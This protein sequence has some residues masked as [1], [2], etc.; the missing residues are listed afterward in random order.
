MMILPVSGYQIRTSPT[1]RKLK[2]QGTVAPS[3]V[4]RNKS[5]A[6]AQ[7]RYIRGQ[8]IVGKGKAG[9]VFYIDGIFQP[10]KISSRC[11]AIASATSSRHGRA[12]TWT[13]IGSPSGEV[14]TRTVALGQPVRLCIC[15]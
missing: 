3:L 12:A 11:R 9:T 4:V 7:L 15:M 8:A 10:P 5:H 2:R 13:L 6:A 14:P 1:K